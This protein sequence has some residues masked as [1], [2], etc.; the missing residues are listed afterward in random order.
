MISTISCI[1]HGHPTTPI[2][3]CI[4]MTWLYCEIFAEY[5]LAKSVVSKACLPP[6][7][8]GG[9]LHELTT[10][11][12][13]T[14]TACDPLRAE[15]FLFFVWERAVHYA[16]VRL[17]VIEM[18]NGCITGGNR[19]RGE[20]CFHRIWVY[21]VRWWRTGR[22]SHI[23]LSWSLKRDE[24]RVGDSIPLPPG[25]LPMVTVK[26]RCGRSTHSATTTSDDANCK[27]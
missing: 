15:K 17:R 18:V 4:E 11:G 23:L 21:P 13:V 14:K 24:C 10:G 12:V 20:H 1:S 3:T 27:T 19:V 26:T 22:E 25:S 7:W 9:M 16:D 2:R 8:L 5:F 6:S